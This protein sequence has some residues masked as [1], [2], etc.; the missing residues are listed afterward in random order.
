[1]KRNAMFILYVSDPSASARFYAGALGAPVIHDAPDFALLVLGDGV[2]LGLWRTADVTP[3]A[4]EATAAASE[5]SVALPDADSLH[6]LHDRLRDA[7]APILQSVTAL[8]FGLNFTV[9]D[10]DGHRLR[11]Y[12]PAAR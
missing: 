4:G 7:G 3:A 12:V 1:M 8:D 11:P 5:L 10:P 6:A 9:A 2:Q